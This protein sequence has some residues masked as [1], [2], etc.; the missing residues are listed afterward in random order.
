[1][2]KIVKIA[3]RHADLRRWRPDRVCKKFRMALLFKN[4]AES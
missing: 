2:K 1:V 3:E 4:N